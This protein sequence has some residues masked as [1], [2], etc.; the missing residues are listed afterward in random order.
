MRKPTWGNYHGLDVHAKVIDHHKGRFNKWL[1]VKI[2][3]SV[4]SMPAAYV[5][6]LLSLASLPAVLSQ[7]SPSL[8]ASFPSWLISASLIAL[9]AWIAQTFLQL[10]L[11][12]VIIV[13][14]NVQA[15]ASDARAAKTF[16]DVET[17][18]DKLNL[19][20]E[21][22][23]QEAVKTILGAINASHGIRDTNT[24]D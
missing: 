17:I 5:F 24:S 3:K 19:D 22:G 6:A 8:K 18:I 12:P 11:L 14:Q 15:E 9:V 1:A 23:L 4:G 2:T 7:V 21:G 13:G 20:T 10:V 16:T